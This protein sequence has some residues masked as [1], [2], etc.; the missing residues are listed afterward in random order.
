MVSYLKMAVDNIQP[1]FDK[2]KV[3]WEKWDCT[4]MCDG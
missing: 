3:E 1:N 2:Y 4:L